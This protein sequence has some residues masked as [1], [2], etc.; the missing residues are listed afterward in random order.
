MSD[1]TTPSP[2][3]PQPAKP[4]P[5]EAAKPALAKSAAAKPVAPKKAA[6]DPA[7]VARRAR[8]GTVIAGAFTLPMVT[9]GVILLAVPL[10]VWYLSTVIRT[11]VV[12]VA[13]IVSGSG[14]AKD[15]NT[16]LGEIDPA[17][18]GGVTLGFAIVGAV[19]VVAG[20]LVSFFVLRAHRV[21]RPGYVTGFGL[22]VGLV[23]ASLLTATVGALTGLIFGSA[24]TVGEVLGNAALSIA[25]TTLGSVAVTIATGVV[26]WLWMGR[27]F[28]TAA[29][30]AASASRAAD[31]SVSGLKPPV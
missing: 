8:R 16:T 18:L 24:R 10:A 1:T 29:E 25:L 30:P 9:L 14:A 6:D 23:I 15:A 13:N 11:L 2:A 21:N 26:V 7:A 4:A 3:E 20:V 12:V 19:F 22:A 27:I 17:A 28:A 5:A 31:R